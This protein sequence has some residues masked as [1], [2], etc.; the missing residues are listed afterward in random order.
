ML[1]HC[2][3]HSNLRNVHTHYWPT[4]KDKCRVALR[5]KAALFIHRQ[6]PCVH[7]WRQWCGW[8]RADA[9]QSVGRPFPAKFLTLY[10]VKNNYRVHSWNPRQ[11]VLTHGSFVHFPQISVREPDISPY[12][13]IEK[14]ANIRNKGG[15]LLPVAWKRF[16]AELE[17]LFAP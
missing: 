4:Q 3:C 7:L 16:Y 10:R 14:I 1:L 15:A 9:S 5:S 2:V 8:A 17:G 11:S 12:I 6:H 13:Q